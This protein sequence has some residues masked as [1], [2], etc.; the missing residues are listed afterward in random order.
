V[1]KIRAVVF[2]MD[3]LLIDTEPIWRRVEI[4]VFGKLGLYLTEEQCME[5]MGVRIAEIV[6]LWHSQRPWKGPS[7]AEVTAQIV[8][9][10]V[11]Y[12]RAEGE[13]KPGV[14]DAL[15]TVDRAGLPIAIASSSSADL[16]NAVVQR[17]NI[18]RYV[19]VI[20]SADDESEGK[21]HPAVYLTA[22]RRLGVDAQSCLAFED[23]P[24]GVLSAK[25]AGMY[26]I[27]VPDPFL[28]NHPRMNEADIRL[29]SLTYFTEALLASLTSSP[30]GVL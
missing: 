24:N 13:P 18:E 4:D 14:C 15:D 16:I 5:M 21:P 28:A 29:D 30:G 9:G 25:A 20:C 17:L 6:E 19:K 12:V 8:K 7:T 1:R 27:V 2:D 22:A 23:S 11:D 26:C 10:V 3:G